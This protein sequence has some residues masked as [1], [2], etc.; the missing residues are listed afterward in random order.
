MHCLK[1]LSGIVEAVAYPDKIAFLAEQRKYRGR[2]FFGDSEFFKDIFI[3]GRGQRLCCVA[4]EDFV[5]ECLIGAFQC[6]LV[7]FQAQSFILTDQ[8]PIM[9]ELLNDLGRELFGQ[10]LAP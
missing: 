6:Y 8:V 4:A 5:A 10:I 9:D 1:G 2:F 7:A 3:I